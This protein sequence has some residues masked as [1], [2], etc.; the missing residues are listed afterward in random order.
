MA[1][2]RS[3]IR[4]RILI[5]TKSYIVVDLDEACR[6]Q[7]LGEGWFPTLADVPRQ[8]I[9]MTIHQMME[10]KQILCIVPD[11]RKAKAVKACFDGDVSAMAPA[12]ILQHHPKAKIY[13]D[14]E[15]ASLL[16]QSAVEAF[17]RV[18]GATFRCR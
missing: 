2:L 1:I 4:R 11:A 18:E 5:R 8:A 14:T 6:K 13:L 15:S 7:Q 17:Q 16:S 10:A 9:S 3:T 12:S